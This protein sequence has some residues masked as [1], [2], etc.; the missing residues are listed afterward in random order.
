MAF[1][2]FRLQTSEI[3]N[4]VIVYAWGECIYLYFKVN[5]ESIINFQSPHFGRTK[6]KKEKITKHKNLEIQ[7]PA[8]SPVNFLTELFFFNENSRE[9]I[10][11]S[12]SSY[13]H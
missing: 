6:M 7:T 8:Q 12:Y 9:Y 5:D 10:I 13:N 2:P 3:S 11:K 4:P 1:L